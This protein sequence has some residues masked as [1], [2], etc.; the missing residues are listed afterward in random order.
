M[1]NVVKAY[2]EDKLHSTYDKL[3][4]MFSMKETAQALSKYYMTVY[5]DVPNNFVMDYLR[6]LKPHN[7]VIEFIYQTTKDDIDR[8]TSVHSAFGS[9]QY[10]MQ[11]KEWTKSKQSFVFDKDLITELI[12][13]DTNLCIPHDVFDRMPY[14]S[15]YMDFS[16]N[17]EIAEK[18]KMDGCMVQVL[19]EKIQD[20]DFFIILAGLYK[21]GKN[22]FMR[23]NVLLNQKGKAE[24]TIQDL[25]GDIVELDHLKNKAGMVK[26]DIPMQTL[27]ITQAL[28][29]LC[30]YEPDIRESSSSK[31]QYNAAKKNKKKSSKA[32]KPMREYKVGER[33][34]IAYRKWTESGVG[35]NK[36]SAATGRH[37]KPHIRKAHWHRYWVGKR[38]SD[39][40]ELVIKWVSECLCGT[41]KDDKLDTVKHKVR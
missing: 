28:L 41:D 3:A 17:P 38:N 27:L 18:V 16:A 8:N 35:K 39:D 25:T 22:T 5:Y 14:K 23:G 15:V 11:Y 4:E 9:F 32:D 31:A 36:N 21:D 7:E 12:R 29:Y 37:N 20:E 24:V 10:I 34:G 1:N 40:R 6:G 30:S 2:Q 19:K 13:T 33:F 26:T